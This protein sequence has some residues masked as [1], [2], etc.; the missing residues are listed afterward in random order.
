MRRSPQLVEQP[1]LASARTLARRYALALALVTALLFGGQWFVQRALRADAAGIHVLGLAGEQRLRSE[2]L[3]RAA[4]ELRSDPA[5]A[6][7]R[8]ALA[9]AC[10]RARAVQDELRARVDTPDDA[11]AADLGAM[12][13]SADAL[14]HGA[15]DP[16]RETAE[17]LAHQA[18]FAAAT[19]RLVADHA[20]A[21]A[22]HI[23]GLRR[24]EIVLLGSLLVALLLEGLLVF[25]PA[26]R[27]SQR[28][29]EAL[30]RGGREKVAIL[31]AIPEPVVLLTRDG[32]LADAPADPAVEHL[33][34][35]LAGPQAA[36]AHAAIREVLA[37]RPVQPLDLGLGPTDRRHAL[38]IARYNDDAVL[39]I[40][41]DVTEQRRQGLSM[42][43]E[44]AKAQQQMGSEL[45]DG[46]CQQLTGLLLLTQALEG[47]A[48]RGDPVAL[49]DITRLREHLSACAVEAR[50][51]SHSL[52]PVVLARHGLVDALRRLCDTSE[53]LHRVRCTCR[54]DG[55]ELGPS[56]GGAAIHLYRIAQE[57][58]ANALRHSRCRSVELSLRRAPDGGLVLEIADD[59]AGLPDAAA[60]GH[61][62]GLHSMNYR[63][64][65]I[66]AWLTITPREGGGTRVSC[67]LPAGPRPAAKDPS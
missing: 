42:L 57:A 65:A 23:E 15:A 9:A 53:A 18:D 20:E 25:G 30:A 6:P 58:V 21:R 66:G 39:G 64:E 11:R 43:D 31:D 27:R 13:R 60:E 33:V 5:A 40:L 3:A 1:P 41:H 46:L 37:G 16:A 35:F 63:A 48:R 54:I 32:K 62:L 59:G 45:H 36:R 12:C 2:Q 17:L 19:E 67:T 38:R 44:V 26:L 49:A 61:G 8:D 22:A 55:D 4:L 47:A 29:L 14:L 28:A 10:A 52:Y 34:A 56:L 24:A 51:I 7:P 50:Q